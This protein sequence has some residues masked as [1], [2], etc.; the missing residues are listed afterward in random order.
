MVAGPVARR[1][2]EARHH[3]LEGRHRLAALHQRGADG[4]GQ[5]RLAHAGVRAGDEQPAQGRVAVRPRRGARRRRAGERGVSAPSRAERSSAGRTAAASAPA[6]SRSSDRV[7]EA[8]T[9]SRRREVPA[10]TVG[11]RIAWAN[12]PRS[13]ARSLARDRLGGVAH[14]ERH[15]L[16]LRVPD[17][18]AVSAERLAQHVPVALELLDAARLL[19]Q[20]AERRHRRRHRG[21]G[22]R[23]GEDQRP[24]RVD[25]VL[26]QRAL[27]A[28][29]GAVGAE[30]LA[31]RAH[32]HV[33]L[34]LEPGGRD[35]AAALGAERRRCRG[36]R[37][38]ARGRRSAAPAP[39]SP[40]AGP[41]RRPSRRRRR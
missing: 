6:A 5:D 22:Q 20:Q 27:A 10:G 4:R 13:S 14:D 24:R 1:L 7:C 15:D 33:H 23:G 36:P 2:V 41:R 8:I 28:D 3:R 9:A 19:A 30:R 12:T 34:V 17:G 32:D 21:R 38:R 29:V 37:P 16:R 18:Q 39:R 26:G 31:E 35:R 40:R 11:G 25:Q